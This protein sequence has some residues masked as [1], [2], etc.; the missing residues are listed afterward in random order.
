MGSLQASLRGVFRPGP[1]SY[2]APLR[3]L[4][5]AGPLLRLIPPAKPPKSQPQLAQVIENQVIPR[6]MQAHMTDEAH[7]DSHE[8][9]EAVT[10]GARAALLA[11]TLSGSLSAMGDLIDAFEQRGAPPAM[12][13]AAL[14]APTARRLVE[15]W[16]E[17]RVSYADVTIGLGR[18]KQLVRG[19]REA[20]SYNG[21]S[22]SEASAALIAPRPG[23]EQTFGLY[24]MGELFRWSGWRTTSDETAANDD[25]RSSVRSDWYDVLCLNVSRAD[26]LGDLRLTLDLARA[27]SRNQDMH[28]LVCG[29]LF[30]ERPMLI[31][32]VG[33]DAAVADAGDALR[34]L[35]QTVGRRAAA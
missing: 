3:N 9:D 33:A 8:R 30:E 5:A 12:L 7:A 10:E 15:L 13:F 16:H 20:T 14:L 17:D 6:L 19:L 1:A 22:D 28:I 24:V 35:G 23:E 25:I 26:R 27:E 34:F 32:E 21:D 29:R 11:T 4:L 18:L 2:S 31:N